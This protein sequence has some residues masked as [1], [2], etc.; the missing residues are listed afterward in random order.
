MKVTMAGSTVKL[1]QERFSR[2]QQIITAHIQELFKIL[3]CVGDKP[4][5]LCEYKGPLCYGNKFSSVYEPI[6]PHYYDKIDP[7]VALV[8]KTK[9]EVWETGKLFIVIKQEVEAREA[10]KMV[11]KPSMKPTGTRGNRPL[12][13]PIASALSTWN[14]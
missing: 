11:K 6:D 1:L 8:R 14:S 12:S 3:P 4:P 13:N 7:R 9:N 2:P 5:S 10:T